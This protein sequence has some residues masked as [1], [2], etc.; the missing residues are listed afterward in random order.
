MKIE[1]AAFSYDGTRQIFHNINIHTVSGE[2]FCLMG[3]NGCGKSTLLDCILG[4]NRL[5]EGKILLDGRDMRTYKP[6]ELARQISYVPQVHIK[7][8][9]YKVRQVVLMGRTAYLGNLGAPRAVDKQ[10]VEQVL[11]EVGISDLADRPYTQLSGGE[12]QMVVLARALAQA[13]PTIVMDEPTSHLDFYNE[14]MFLEKVAHLVLDGKRSVVMATHSPNQAFFL[15]NCGVPVRVGL[16]HQG[17]FYAVGSPR[18]ILSTDN[19]HKV[20]GIESR[21]LQD[22]VCRQLMPVKTDKEQII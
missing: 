7:S 3:R 19:M 14:L 1:N 9:P 6:M 10:V 16:M 18:D 2:L 5:Q 13:T 17:Q 22:G 20:Y 12:M 21:L 8:F 4:I 11:A 15:E